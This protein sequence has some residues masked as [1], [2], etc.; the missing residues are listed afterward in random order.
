MAKPSEIM[1]Y[2]TMSVTPFNKRGTVDEG[3]LK[4]HLERIAAAGNGVFLASV[5]TGEAKLLSRDEIRRVYQVGVKVLK[6]TVPVYAAG[7]GLN[8]TALVIDM[9]NEA[10]AIGVDA[11]YMYGPRTGEANTPTRQEIDQFFADVFAKVKGPL[12][13]ANN[14]TV[15]NYQVPVEVFSGL[16]RAHARRITAFPSADPNFFYNVRFIDAVAPKPVY[17]SMTT[18]LLGLLAVGVRGALGHEGNVAPRLCQSIFAAW[19]KGDY[20]RSAQS[21]ATLMRLGV[22]LSKYG[23][24]RSQKA[25]L[26]ILG[27]PSSNPRRPYLPLD[28]AARKELASVL[29][30]L[31]IRK[32]EGLA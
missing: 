18:Q 28:D 22:V 12:L 14:T 8:D 2:H 17:T 9:A 23:N 20:K 24:P 4:E 19:A 32:I 11:A 25:A 21:Y 1:R 16:A 15:V 31:E 10:I 30:E 13:P 6:G 27:L 3:A 29:D 26:E 5:G 7:L